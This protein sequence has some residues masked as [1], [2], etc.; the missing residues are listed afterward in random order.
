MFDSDFVNVELKQFQGGKKFPYTFDESGNVMDN[1][2]RAANNVYNDVKVSDVPADVPDVNDGREVVPFP[3]VIVEYGP[4]DVYGPATAHTQG[5]NNVFP[6]AIL[7]IYC[8]G[9][10]D[11]GIVPTPAINV[12]SLN[13]PLVQENLSPQNIVPSVR[14]PPP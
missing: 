13:L 3:L 10:I 7:S 6:A 14:R 8:F 5:L 4:E 1:A 11:I 9:I 2:V 12:S